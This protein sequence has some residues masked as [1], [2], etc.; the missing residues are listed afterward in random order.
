MA[1][2]PTSA[3]F[4]ARAPGPVS[5]RLYAT[6]GGGTG[7]FRSAFPVPFGRRHSLF[8]HPV[9]PG[10]S[11]P[12]TIGLPR[13]TTS[14]DPDGVSMFRTRETRPGRAPSVSRGR[15]CSHDRPEIHGRRLPLPNGQPLSPRSYCPPR[16]AGV[17]G[18]HQGFTGI[19]PS[20]LPL[21]CGP[22]TEP[23]PLGFPL[24]LRT[25]ASRTRRRT[26]GRGHVSNT[27]PKSRP[28]HHRTSPTDSLT[29][30]DLMSQSRRSS[31]KPGK[32]T[33]KS[34]SRHT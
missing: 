30:C 1:H 23:A 2:L 26:S 17:T 9:P 13:Q 11:A 22:G 21:T 6:A 12:L 34:A 3:R 16:G 5:S 10:D 8:G 33:H 28:R 24:K 14:T 25:P 18:H 4:R 31:V 15:R 27:D 7:Q 32:I 19:H 20:S 29:T